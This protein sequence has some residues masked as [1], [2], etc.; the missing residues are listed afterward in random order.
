M[1]N[2]VCSSIK[3]RYNKEYWCKNNSYNR[4]VVGA[5]NY[6]IFVAKLGTQDYYI[7]W[8]ITYHILFWSAGKAGGIYRDTG[9]IMHFI[10][11]SCFSQQRLP[12]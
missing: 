7:K 4:T 10:I 5:S 1:F 3:H 8:D 12:C 2:D 9:N 6:G 11:N